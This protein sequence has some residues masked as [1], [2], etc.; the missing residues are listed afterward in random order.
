MLK[1]IRRYF[2]PIIY[3]KTGGVSL[4]SQR[5][6][7]LGILCLCWIINWWRSAASSEYSPK[8][9][10][11]L[12]PMNYN[13]KWSIRAFWMHSLIRTWNL[14]DGCIIYWRSALMPKSSVS[15]L[16]SFKPF[17]GHTYCR[18]E[19]TTKPLKNSIS[20]AWN[21]AHFWLP[22]ILSSP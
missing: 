21:V 1:E 14:D 9:T 4:S 15:D 17:K 19:A 18:F 5:W 6:V 22:M 8:Y 11:S 3:T 10:Q 7:K 16:R 2:N 12:Q 20:T 13:F